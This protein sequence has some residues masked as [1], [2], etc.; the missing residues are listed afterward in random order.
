MAS[1]QVSAHPVAPWLGI[2]S[3]T[4]S[5]AATRVLVWYG[6][7]APTTVVLLWNSEISCEARSQ[8]FLTSGCS[9]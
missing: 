7:A 5:P 9:A 4:L 2:V 1:I 6:Q 8:Y 3:A